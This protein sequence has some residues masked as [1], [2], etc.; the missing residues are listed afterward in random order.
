MNLLTPY[1]HHSELQVITAL[2]VIST[3]CKTPQYPLSLFPACL[4][5]ISRSP[6]T[7]SNSDNSSVSRSQVLFKAVRA[8][9][10]STVNSTIAPSLLSLPCRAQLNCQPSTV[11]FITR[12]TLL[13]T[14]RHEP[15]RKPRFHCYWITIP[16]P[17]PSNSRCTAV[18]FEVPAQ[19][20]VYRGVDAAV[21]IW[22]RIREVLSSNLGRDAGYPDWSI[23][24]FFSVP[25]C[26]CG[27]CI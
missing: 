20:R 15:H 5:F 24:W 16:L 3:L 1:T 17:L 26:N 10:L 18:P 8:E 12:L 4:V 14:F 9:L 2:L 13:M 22:S 21:K 23:S 19:Q 11:N 7:A 27:G 6:A 25:L